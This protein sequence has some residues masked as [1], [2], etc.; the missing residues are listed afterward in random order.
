MAREEDAGPA[1]EPEED[2]SGRSHEGGGRPITVEELHNSLQCVGRVI[3]VRMLCQLAP[4]GR[5]ANA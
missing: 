4:A 3:K 1:D 2:E 5:P